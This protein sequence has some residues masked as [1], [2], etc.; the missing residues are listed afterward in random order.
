MNS[1]TCDH[2]HLYTHTLRLPYTAAFY[3]SVIATF[4]HGNDGQKTREIH[5]LVDDVLR[6]ATIVSAGDDEQAVL[7]MQI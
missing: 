1:A 2:R 6:L 7:D 5:G 3:T 4:V